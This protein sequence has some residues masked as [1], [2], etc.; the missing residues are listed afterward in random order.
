M[1]P[2]LTRPVYTIE[3]DVKRWLH[4]STEPTKNLLLSFLVDV[5]QSQDFEGLTTACALESLPVL[6][7]S[8]SMDSD[9]Q[10]FETILEEIWQDHWL[11]D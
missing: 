1:R 3:V 11:V 10:K 4:G 8:F 9:R 5:A 2:W 6:W 7:F